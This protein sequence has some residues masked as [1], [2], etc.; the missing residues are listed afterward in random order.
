MFSLELRKLNNDWLDLLDPFLRSAKGKRVIT[1]LD[2]FLIGNTNFHP[3]KS[4]LLTPFKLISPRD[5]RV[6]IVGHYPYPNPSHATGLP[7]SNPKNVPMSLSAKKIFEAIISDV[8]GSFPQN[9]SLNYLCSQGVFLINRKFTTGL[10]FNRYPTGHKGVGWEEFSKSVIYLI[11]KELENLV[12]MLWGASA[13][14]VE[15]VIQQ[16]HLVL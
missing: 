9:G 5:I 1:E 11:S 8:G 3:A 15:P 2:E 16:K 4:D 13:K 12:F 14:E 7:F 6:I 10:P